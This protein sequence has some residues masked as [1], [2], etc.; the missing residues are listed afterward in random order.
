MMPRTL[1]V[2][3]RTVIVGRSLGVQGKPWFLSLSC[4]VLIFTGKRGLNVSG[5]TL[6]N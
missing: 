6:K 5:R 2:K 4:C 3:E 1:I